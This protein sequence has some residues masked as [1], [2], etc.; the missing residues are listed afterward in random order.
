[1]IM[2]YVV[3]CGGKPIGP[4]SGYDVCKMYD[5]GDI[6]Q[7]TRVHR[8]GDPDGFSSKLSRRLGDTTLFTLFSGYRA[9]LATPPVAFMNEIAET[10][11][12]QT[13]VLNAI[14]SDLRYLRVVLGLISLM[15][16]SIVVFGFR[17]SAR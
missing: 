17:I 6:D 5:A 13:V 15:I 3:E 10:I 7:D 11:A 4:L 2:L 8:L 9:V 16:L 1:M 14:R 12:A